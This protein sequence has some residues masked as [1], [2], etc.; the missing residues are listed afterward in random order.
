MKTSW[1]VLVWSLMFFSVVRAE[2]QSS[3]PAS[4]IWVAEVLGMSCPLCANNIEKQLKRDKTVES[5]EIDLGKGDVKITYSREVA[6]TGSIKKAIE[7]AGFSTRK[8]YPL[9]E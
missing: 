5:V 6:E 1:F 7:D 4:K 2:D 8:I 9:R 3:Q